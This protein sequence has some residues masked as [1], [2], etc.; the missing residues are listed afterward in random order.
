VIHAECTLYVYLSTVLHNKL[1]H[2]SSY[3]CRLF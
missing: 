1:K 2:S 3:Y